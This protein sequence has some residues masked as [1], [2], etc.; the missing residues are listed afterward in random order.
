MGME[1]VA[2]FGDDF[3]IDES[4]Q[5]YSSFLAYFR[6]FFS[7]FSASLTEPPS[8]GSRPDGLPVRLVAT[9]Y[10]PIPPFHPLPATHIYL[11]VSVSKRKR[12][13]MSFPPTCQ[14]KRKEKTEL[15]VVNAEFFQ[16]L[17]DA[18]PPMHIRPPLFFFPCFLQPERRSSNHHRRKH[19]SDNVPI[20]IAVEYNPIHT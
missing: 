8:H 19:S 7:A 12:R 4:V 16:T 10:N 13:I 18:N 20:F 17:F 6:N 9:G 1:R 14:R 15:D 2:G 5:A 3:S 11:S